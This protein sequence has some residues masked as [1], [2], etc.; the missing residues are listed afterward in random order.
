MPTP[1]EMLERFQDSYALGDAAI[2]STH[3]DFLEL[4]L[5]AA[6]AGGPEFADAFRSGFIAEGPGKL[7]RR[8]P[9]W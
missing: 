3:R 6:N 7:R 2:D 4:C 5:A 1:Q 8:P 9:S